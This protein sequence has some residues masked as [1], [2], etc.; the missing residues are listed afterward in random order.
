MEKVDASALQVRCLQLPL[1]GMNLLLPNTC[2]AEVAEYQEPIPAPHAPNWM[3]GMLMW[4]GSSIPLISFEQLLG[5]EQLVRGSHVRMA[6][7]NSFSGNRGLPFYA[8]ELQGIPRIVN[9]RDE[10]IEQREQQ[11]A[12]LAPVQCRVV[13][14][15]DETIIPD[16]DIV[17]GM[18][19][20]LGLGQD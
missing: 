13:V 8:M 2:V 18:L 15:G 17:E 11:H 4:R 1:S 7:F 12:D 16:L 19:I 9:V 6:I 14:E 10:D 20:Q 5:G 3:L